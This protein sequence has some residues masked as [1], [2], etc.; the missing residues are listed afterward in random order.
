M[1]TPLPRPLIW[2]FW[3]LSILIA[4]ASWRGLVV[5][6]G[7]A[8]DHMAH[9]LTLAP[10]ALWGHLIFGPMAL[11]LAPFQMWQDLRSRRP[12]LHRML[13]YGYG[14]SVMLAAIASLAL[15]PHFM[16]QL[17]AAGGFALLAFAWLGTTALGISAARNRAFGAH[18]RWMIRSVTLTFAAVTLR[19]IMAPL[20]IAG[21]S[22]TDTYLI[23]AWASWIPSLVLVELWM[24][25]KPRVA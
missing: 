2:A 8:M 15:L 1:F 24:R 10:L 21:W 23:T 6:L 9:Y 7:I 11:M 3:A 12:R 22:V 20:M 16:G 14:L 5:P 25:R 4:L 19:L 18:R 17:S 13:G